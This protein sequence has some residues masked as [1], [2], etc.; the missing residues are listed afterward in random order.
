MKN[1]NQY[2]TAILSKNDPNLTKN[3][4]IFPQ[5]AKTSFFSTQKTKLSITNL[6]I[7]TNGLQDN[8]KTS[9]LGYFGPEWL[10]LDSFRPKWGKTGFFQISAF[11]IFPPF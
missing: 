5:N 10:I 6:Q 11:N 4:L 8:V 7:L 1:Q 2:I 3:F 9:I